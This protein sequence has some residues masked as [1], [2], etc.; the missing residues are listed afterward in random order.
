MLP[1]E[2]A[3]V[4]LIRDASR[5]APFGRGDETLV[6]TSVRDTWELDTTQ[7]RITNP[8]WDSF[9]NSTL[10]DASQ[11]LGTSMVKAQLYKLL[12]YETGSFFKRHKDSE[13]APGMIATLSICLPSRYKGGEVHLSHTGK[14]HVFDISKSIFDLS[15]LAWYADVTHEIKPVT[16]GHRL[17]LI[18]NIIHMGDGATSAEFLVKQDQKL[19]KIMSMLNLCFPT[20]KRLLYFLEHKYSRASLEIDHLKG[21]D[22]AV[23]T[24]SYAGG[25]YYEDDDEDKGPEL[26]MDTVSTCGAEALASMVE[27]HKNEILWPDPYSTRDADSES[28]GQD[29][30]NEGAPREYRYHD[31]AAV[32]IPKSKLDQ[33]VGSNIDTEVLFDLVVRDLEDHPEDPNVREVVVEFLS[34]LDN[35][36]WDL[37][38]MVLSLAWGMEKDTMFRAAIC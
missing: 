6:D 29:T 11:R 33:F 7:F 17:A 2:S 13:K 26:V 22:R 16:E 15:A 12:L 10:Y 25:W 35:A 36:A 5:Q 24:G 20:P 1:L 32:L 21:Q 9:L 23:C 8:A 30:G 14:G 38:P 34:R 27:L 18:Y 28:E 3:Q 37:S 31:S 4:P 19:H